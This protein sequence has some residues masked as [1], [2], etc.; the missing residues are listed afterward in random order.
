MSKSAK[1]RINKNVPDPSNNVRRISE[2][3]LTRKD[4][5]TDEFIRSMRGSLANSGNSARLER[6]PDRVL[7]SGLD[8]CGKSPT[9]RSLAD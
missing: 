2:E 3:R 6:D 8:S 1:Q 4:V 9:S 5:V 7:G